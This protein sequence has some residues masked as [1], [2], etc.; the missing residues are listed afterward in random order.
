MKDGKQCFEIPC[1]FSK[2]WQKQARGPAASFGI[3]PS[4]QGIFADDRSVYE[5]RAMN[6]NRLEIRQVWVSPW[7]WLISWGSSLLFS[8]SRSYLSLRLHKL[9][10]YRTPCN[11]RDYIT[12]IQDIV[13]TQHDLFS[14][15]SNAPEAGQ[16]TSITG[17]LTSHPRGCSDHPFWASSWEGQSLGYARSRHGVINFRNILIYSYG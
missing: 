1:E 10:D 9:S 13:L 5:E 8:L 14:I 17:S 12:G 7:P 15:D 4:F 11:L 16:C 3:L 6:T 2:A